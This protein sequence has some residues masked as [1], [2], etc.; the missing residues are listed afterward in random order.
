MESRSAPLAGIRVLDLTHVLAGPFCTQLLADAGADVVKVEPPGGEF[1]RVRG[2]VRSGPDGA[3]LSSYYAAVNRGKRNVVI[4]LKNAH[5]LDLAR[6]LVATA[7]VVV[8]NFAPGSLNRLGLD[9]GELRARH[10]RLVTV[11]ITLYGSE[12]TAGDLASR[13]GLAIVAEAES[14]LTAMTPDRDGRPVA[15]RV[16]LGDMAAGLNAYAA[17][18]TAL[19][20]RERSGVGRHVDVSMVRTLLSLNSLGIAIAQIPFP[21]GVLPPSPAG[22]GIFPTRNGY[23]T[24]GVNSDNLFRRLAT[25]M[26][27]PGLADDLRYRSYEDRDERAA[28]VAEIISAWSSLLDSETVISRA[29]AAGVPCGRVNT[30]ED[31]LDDPTFRD[32]RLIQTTG[33]GLGGT[34]DTASNPMGYAAEDRAIPRLDEHV[35]EVLA[36]IG[37]DDDE[38]ASLRR[39]GALAPADEST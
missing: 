38:L 23:V 21:G 6:R 35:R 3:A 33:D 9:L 20:E 1:S 24:F 39:L 8:E 2:S 22:Y 10:P 37:V 19:Y 28:E 27:M 15:L 29:E 31:V 25:A 7:D 26:G 14:T 11:S 34:I 32:L 30:P 5:G 16:P 36:E 13:L 4:D 17:I 12:P 18:V